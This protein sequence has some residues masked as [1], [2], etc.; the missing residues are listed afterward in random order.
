M[1]LKPLIDL[2]KE[3][4][5]PKQPQKQESAIRDFQFKLE[6]NS[7]IEEP[8]IPDVQYDMGVDK[9]EHQ[10][11]LELHISQQIIKQEDRGDEE[12]V[13]NTYRLELPLYSG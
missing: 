6:V 4:P 1:S 10:S 7:A 3:R 5:K 9:Y 11:E 8:Q 13:Q 12:P 2:T